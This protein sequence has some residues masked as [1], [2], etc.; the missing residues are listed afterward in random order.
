VRTV[1]PGSCSCSTAAAEIFSAM[2]IFKG[3]FILLNE[4][5]N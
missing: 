3:E 5:L 1:H 2:T 4:G